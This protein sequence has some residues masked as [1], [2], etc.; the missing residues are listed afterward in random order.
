ML[1]VLSK[2]NLQTE[3]SVALSQGWGGAGGLC[4]TPCLLILQGITGI[5]FAEGEKCYI[6][7]QPKAHIPEVDAMAKASLSSELVRGHLLSFFKVIFV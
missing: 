5:R 7:A 1:L 6:K 4:T 2:I 3:N